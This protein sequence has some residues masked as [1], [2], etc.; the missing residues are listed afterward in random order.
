MGIWFWIS[1]ALFAGLLLW[2]VAGEKLIAAVFTTLVYLGAIHL[3]GGVSVFG[4]IAAHP[5]YA[6]IG[7]PAFLLAG[8]IWSIGKWWLFLNARKLDYKET[9]LAFLE[10]HGV[11]GA[12]LDTPVPQQLRGDRMV[13]FVSK[14][15]A[16][17]NKIR[18]INWMVFWPFSVVWTC[19][20]EPWR[21]IYEALVTLYQRMADRVW[22]D[23]CEDDLVPPGFEPVKPGCELEPPRDSES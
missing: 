23:L 21:M 10:A 7:L 1:T 22:V 19:L 17:R 14:P 13:P 16:R 15:L 18:I 6:Y 20:N 5:E 4:T 12:T 9:R 2:E 3:F 8:G 11:V